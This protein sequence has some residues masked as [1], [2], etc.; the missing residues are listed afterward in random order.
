MPQKDARLD[1]KLYQSEKDE[2]VEGARRARSHSLSDFVLA[3][4]LEKARETKPK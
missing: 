3:A 4:A 2:L 1:L